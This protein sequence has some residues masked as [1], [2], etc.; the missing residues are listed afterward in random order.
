MGVLIVEDS[1]FQAR[2]LGE[3]L[4]PIGTAIFMAGNVKEAF[5][6][7]QTVQISLIISDLYMPKK[8]DGLQFIRRIK[9]S[10]SAAATELFVCTIDN[11]ME[12]LADLK[13]LG[14]N[15]VFVKPYNPNEMLRAVRQIFWC[16]TDKSSPFISPAPTPP[17]TEE[18]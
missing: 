12:T 17:L 15:E 14:V 7:L 11:S 8:E 16:D 18:K 6:V 4:K 1:A 2:I 5:E 13:A 10:S 3:L 9:A